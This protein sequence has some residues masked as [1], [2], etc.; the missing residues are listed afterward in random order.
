MKKTRIF[1]MLLSVT[2][3]LLAG[4]NRLE[5]P[6]GGNE[7]ASGADGRVTFDVALTIPTDENPATK[8]MADDPDIRNIYVVAF[9]GSN[10]LNEFSLAIPLNDSNEPNVDGSGNYI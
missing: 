9:G 3:A 4:C 10:Y 1:V 7:A 8:A 2:A 6:M 5:E